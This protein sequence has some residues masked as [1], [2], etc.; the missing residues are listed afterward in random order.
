M[1]EVGGDHVQLGKGAPRPA[2]HVEGLVASCLGKPGVLQPAADHL[3]GLLFAGFSALDP[4][5]AER[6]RDVAPDCAVF[7][8][9]QLQ[10]AAAEV[11]DD[12]ACTGKGRD[13][14]EA[15]VACFLFRADDLAGQADPGRRHRRIRRPLS[16]SRTAA[17]ATTWASLHSHV[18]QEQLVAAQRGERLALAL[19]GHVAVV[20]E[21]RAEAGH[22]L[23]VEDRRGRP[24]PP[25]ID[26]Q[27]DRVRTD[28]D[29]CDGLC[30]T[31]LRP[32]DRAESAAWEP[33]GPSSAPAR[34]PTATGCS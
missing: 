22:H 3:A 20:A 29:D 11:A 28:V 4:K 33:C 24:L 12:A 15:R 5:H 30:A 2:D 19:V 27:P 9:D 18:A 17:V 34:G 1:R 23:L 32:I 16:A 10:A 25:R 14:A 7:H 6:K 26:D 31:R 21:T 8:L 13:H